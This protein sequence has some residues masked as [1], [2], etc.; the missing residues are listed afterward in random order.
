MMDNIS[1][2]RA[3]SLL[4]R[5]AERDDNAELLDLVRDGEAMLNGERPVRPAHEV[6]REIER[7]TE[8]G[9]L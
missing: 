3:V 4:R 2:I 9:Q 8:V 5:L 6:V 7:A 1:F